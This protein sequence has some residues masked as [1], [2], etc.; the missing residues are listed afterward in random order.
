[1]GCQVRKG[2]SC[3]ESAF[4]LRHFTRSNLFKLQ[5]NYI[6]LYSFFFGKSPRLAKSVSYI[7]DLTIQKKIQKPKHTIFPYFVLQI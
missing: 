7:S 1:M 4:V 3:F 5:I 2:G 6:I